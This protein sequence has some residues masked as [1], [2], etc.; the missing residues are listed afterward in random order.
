[1]KHANKETSEKIQHLRNKKDYHG[2]LQLISTF[3]NDKDT[4]LLK[5]N[6]Y[7]SLQKWEDVIRSCDIG[8]DLG[9]ES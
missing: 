7:L 2:M 4:Y 5:A 6:T 3:P 1:M 8:L 9:E